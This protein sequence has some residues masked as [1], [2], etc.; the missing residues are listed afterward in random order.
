MNSLLNQSSV[1]T[2]TAWSPGLSPRATGPILKRLGF[3]RAHR[4][5]L[6]F[7]PTRFR[8]DPRARDAPE[9]RPLRKTDEKD[10][11]RLSSRAYAHHIDSAFGPGGDVRVWAPDCVKGLFTDTKHPIDYGCSFV[12]VRNRRVIGDVIVIKGDEG[13]HMMDLSVDPSYRGRGIGTALMHRA[14][15]A[16]S[17]LRVKR[18]DL[19]VTVENPTGAVGLYR[20]L[21]FRRVT[22]PPRWPG[23]WINEAIRRR[24][25]LRMSGE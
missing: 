4:E 25:G 3:R 16:L 18:V 15:G 19:S 1:F 13:P 7:N 8:A 22:G 11:V 17:T 20:R 5:W 9:I 14:L 24:M 21:G 6:Y 2:I 23:L 10:I 12:Y